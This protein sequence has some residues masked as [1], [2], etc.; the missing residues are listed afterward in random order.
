MRPS[1]PTAR[2]AF[3]TRDPPG[4][5]PPQMRLVA[6]A[7]LRLVQRK[8]AWITRQADLDGDGEV[9][10]DD[11]NLAYSRVAPLVRRHTALSGGLVGGFVTAYS[12]LR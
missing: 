12:A 2:A 4:P 3:F 10:V 7:A 1:H 11:G 8:L 5:A 9:T 6:L